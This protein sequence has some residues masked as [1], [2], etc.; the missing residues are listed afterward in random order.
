MAL[1][2]TTRKTLYNA[3]VINA[4]DDSSSEI[5]VEGY[6][7]ATI[8]ISVTAKSGTSPTLDLDVECSDDEDTGNWHKEGDITQINDPTVTFLAP[9]HKVT[10]M[11]KW[12]RLNS[13]AVPGGSSSPQMTVTAFAVLKT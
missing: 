7:E 2:S 8:Y 13:P 6:L 4:A 9:V 1:H 10:N 11:G 12:L 5:N 3:K